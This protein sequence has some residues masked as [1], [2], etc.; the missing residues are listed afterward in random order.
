[1]DEHIAREIDDIVEDRWNEPTRYELLE[2]YTYMPMYSPL[3]PC[4]ECGEPI[5]DDRGCKYCN[6]DFE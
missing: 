5:F 2:K 3:F 6:M 4:A 1:M